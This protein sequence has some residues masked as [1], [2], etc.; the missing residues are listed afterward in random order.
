MQLLWEISLTVFVTG[1]SA[2]GHLTSMLLATDWTEYSIPE[3]CN[4]I[5]GAVP[6]SGIYDLE[7]IRTSCV[8]EESGLGLSEADVAEN[9]PLTNSALLS[10]I[11]KNVKTV[12]GIVG[13][14]NVDGAPA[15]PSLAREFMTAHGGDSR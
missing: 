7:P 10:S 4:V 13:S 15:R 9:S 14:T 1:H 8:Q 6:M 3:N 2:G 11:L 5:A 12:T